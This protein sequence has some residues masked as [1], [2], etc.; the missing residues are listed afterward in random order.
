MIKKFLLMSIFILVAQSTFAA[1]KWTGPV[2]VK[3]VRVESNQVYV[4]FNGA[5][6]NW[7]SCSTDWSV[8][9][10]NVEDLDRILSVLL[11]AKATASPVE[12]GVV[13]N[14]CHEGFRRLI[15]IWVK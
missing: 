13:D 10:H 7:A 15:G 3:E 14:D 6:S 1:T 8:Y 9:P 12:V 5:T 11:T 2:T 4:R